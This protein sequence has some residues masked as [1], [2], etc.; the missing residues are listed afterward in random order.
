MDADFVPVGASS[1]NRT[2]SRYETQ[3][4][5]EGFDDAFLFDTAGFSRV[6]QDERT[7]NFDLQLI[8]MDWL[9][10]D[11]GVGRSEAREPQHPETVPPETA[12]TETEALSTRNATIRNNFNWGVNFNQLAGRSRGEVTSSLP[13]TNNQQRRGINTRRASDAEDIAPEETTESPMG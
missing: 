2:R 7:V 5:K 11:A 12:P 8:P 13:R 9:A 6:A 1:S 3:Y 4:A 10:F